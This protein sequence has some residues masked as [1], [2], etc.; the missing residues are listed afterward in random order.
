M[1]TLKN[2]LL[3][4]A[5]ILSFNVM[6]FVHELGHFLAAR[7]RGLQIDK[8]QVWFGK[9]IWSKTING[10]QY[11]LGWIPAGGFVALPQLA[12]MDAI[13]GERTSDKPLPPISP[14]DKIIVA[15]AGP[16]F[17]LLLAL[18]IGLI[19]W[20]VGK[21]ADLIHSTQIGY[22]QKDSPAE[23]AGLQL[24]D[25]ILAV[26]G[27]PVKGFIGG[28]DYI[29]ESIVLSQ[30]DQIEFTI[31]RAN[32]T[33]PRKILT[34]F[35][36]APTR[37]YE[38]RALRTVGISYSNPA[39]VREMVANSPGVKAG[40]QKGDQIVAVDGI[41]IWSTD[42][43]SQY[44][45]TKNYAES[46]FTVQRGQETKELKITPALPEKPNDKTPML[47]IAWDTEDLFDK[48][49]VYLNPID[50]CLSS[51]KMMVATI[52][53]LISPNS[54]IGFDQ[55]NGPLGIAKAKYDLLNSEFGIQRLLAFL[56][57]INVNLAIFNMLPFPVL[58][59]GHTTMAVMELI[60]RRPVKARILEYVQSACALLLIT[61]FLYIT[62]KD[63]GGYFGPKEKNVPVTFAP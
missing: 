5:V 40:L 13:E 16:I 63:V 51:V 62:S 3:I 58:D 30:G 38:R 55:M 26:N 8:F 35:E 10:V 21:P 19:V 2:I 20:K 6:I 12:P 49:L 37:W 29:K 47:G 25:N 61:L 43:I 46:S 4:I 14:W 53:A 31:Q 33:E 24:G 60:T 59:G 45:Q 7:W 48:H 42:Q 11:G 39:I 17:S 15:I 50:Q 22:I 9:P 57:L 56:V 27:K 54:S 28:L 36:T 32:E 41:K 18:V 1:D 34:S 52:T 23:K 44:L